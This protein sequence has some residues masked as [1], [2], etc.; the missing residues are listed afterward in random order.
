MFRVTWPF[1]LFVQRLRPAWLWK[2]G[3]V[4]EGTKVLRVCAGAQTYIYTVYI[5]I[6]I[7][8]MHCL[9]HF[10]RLASFFCMF[11]YICFWS[12]PGLAAAPCS[13]SPHRR[14]RAGAAAGAP[15][16]ASRRERGL[17]C[18]AAAAGGAT[19]RLEK[20]QPKIAQNADVW[21]GG[22]VIF[23]VI[24]K[25]FENDQKQE[26]YWKMVFYMACHILHTYVQ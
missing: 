19:R 12:F 20:E 14:R 5:Y 9:G 6:D 3:V 13:P 24:P 7:Q 17:G 11:G 4:K 22:E 16:V 1:R 25:E 18:A 21:R 8:C 15:G 2:N 26:R 23:C 10:F